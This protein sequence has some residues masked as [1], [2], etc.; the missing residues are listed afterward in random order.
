MTK[1]VFLVGCPRS[2]TTLLQSMLFAHPAIVSF[3]ETFFFVHTAPRPGSR[4]DRLGMPAAGAREALRTLEAVVVDLEPRAVRRPRAPLTFKGYAQVFVA[5]LDAAA[6]QAGATVWV[7][8]TPDHL[9][10]MTAIERHISDAHFVHLI[11]DGAATVASMF[12]V[13]QQHPEIFGRQTVPELVERWCD[14][15]RRTHECTAR[16]NHA[17]VSY[18]RLVADA[19]TVLSSLCRFLGIPDADDMVKGMVSDYAS[20]ADR[21]IGRVDRLAGDVLVSEPWKT[22]AM[23]RIANRN[24]A[25]LHALFGPQQRALIEDSVATL[26][27]TLAE[28][29]FL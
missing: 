17:F 8:K 12:D 20:H 24:D 28:I 1:R 26:E 27:P 13:Q 6:K 15:V 7:E 18:E 25:K 5:S 9:L 2:G 14:C 19:A 10:H 11:R 16:P 21:V 22:G 4:R 3:P 23:E 29:E